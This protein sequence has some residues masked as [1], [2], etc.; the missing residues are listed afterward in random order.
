MPSLAGRNS[1]SSGNRRDDSGVLTPLSPGVGAGFDARA[2]GQSLASV[3]NNPNSRGGPVQG[4]DQSWGGWF[5]N[6]SVEPGQEVL[7]PLAPGILPDISRADFDPYLSAI[8]DKYGRFVD[9][10]EH[11]SREQNSKASA[12]GSGASGVEQDG[13]KTS[14]AQGEGLLACMREIPSLYFDEDF[15]LERGATFQAACPY[16]SVPANMMLQEKLSHYLDLV[17]VHLVKEISARSESFYE[18][19]GALEELYSKIIAANER[20][21][22]LKASMQQ[23]DTGLIEPARQV[24]KLGLRKDNLLKLHQ[25]LKLVEHVHQS[26]STL[27]LVSDSSANCIASV[28]TLRRLLDLDTFWPPR[29]GVS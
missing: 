28:T 20:V 19:L 22:M 18:A 5:F 7:P 25:K 6:A 8:A 26:Q 17:E 3:L 10:Q 14:Q 2:A 24:Q 27:R 23:M 1:V 11:D 21:S 13:K 4:N 9:I 16:S 15:A 29:N 12:L